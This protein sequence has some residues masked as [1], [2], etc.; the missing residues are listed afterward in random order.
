M[1][2]RALSLLT[3]LVVW[4]LPG[5]EQKPAEAN[6][7]APEEVEPTPAIPTSINPAKVAALAS[8]KPKEGS[9]IYDL[10]FFDA[11]IKAKQDG[12][13]LMIDFYTVW[14]VPCKKMDKTAFKDKVVVPWLLDHAMPIKIDA[15][16]EKALAKR[17]RVSGYP[18]LLFLKPDG[19]EIGRFSGFSDTRAFVKQVAD[20]LGIPAPELPPASDAAEPAGHDAGGVGH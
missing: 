8:A 13:P 3:L 10:N 12:K 4:T 20:V 14:C 11:S 17:F 7:A 18:T 19:K 16:K 5:C 1:K 9:P 6:T 2:C 15:E